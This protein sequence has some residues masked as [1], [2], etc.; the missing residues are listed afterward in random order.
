MRMLKTFAFRRLHGSLSQQEIGPTDTRIFCFA[1]LP[2][3]LGWYY[4]NLLISIYYEFSYHE[5]MTLTTVTTILELPR[6][7]LLHI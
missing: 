4:D 7:V 2:G 5:P 1:F 6:R 3:H